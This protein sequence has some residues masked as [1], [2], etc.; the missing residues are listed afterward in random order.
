MDV[1]SDGV[2]ACGELVAVAR[3]SLADGSPRQVL[4]SWSGREIAVGGR[5]SRANRA[6]ATDSVGL[7][8]SLFGM[9]SI[10]SSGTWLVKCVYARCAGSEKRRVGKECV[11]AGSTR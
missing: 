2:E 10:L 9:A 5:W 6:R 8:S 3:H 7:K 1:G 11:I 4:G